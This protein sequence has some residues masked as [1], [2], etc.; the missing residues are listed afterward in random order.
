[1]MKYEDLHTHRLLVEG[2]RAVDVGTPPP[3][4]ARLVPLHVP[5]HL[6]R[7]YPTLSSYTA[8]YLLR[9]CMCTRA[10]Q[11]G[12]YLGWHLLLLPPAT[13]VQEQRRP[14]PWGYG[15]PRGERNDLPKSSR[16][17]HVMAQ[18]GRR[19]VG[20]ATAVANES[21]PTICSPEQSSL[22]PGERSGLSKESVFNRI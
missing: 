6:G 18:R 13:D 12:I 19:R 3:W 10:T 11:A 16:I 21:G 7:L 1:M 15:E 8:S 4:R 9:G 20:G 17:F 14:S 2:A 22:L 5:Y